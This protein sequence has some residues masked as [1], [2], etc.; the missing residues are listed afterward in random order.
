MIKCN[1]IELKDTPKIYFLFGKK[2]YE[3]IYFRGNYIHKFNDIKFKDYCD[4]MYNI[5]FIHKLDSLY[6]KSK[7]KIDILAWIFYVYIYLYVYNLFL[8]RK[9]EYSR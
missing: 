8:D 2:E 1:Y 9:E 5:G 3:K 6:E 7:N 4:F